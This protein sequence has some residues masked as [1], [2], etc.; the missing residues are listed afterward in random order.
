LIDFH[1]QTGSHA[2][3]G[4]RQAETYMKLAATTND[5][6]IRSR[7]QSTTLSKATGDLRE[8][9]QRSWHEPV[10][11]LHPDKGG[12]RE[13]MVRLN[14]RGRHALPRGGGAWSPMTVMRAMKRLGISGE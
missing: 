6:E 11:E 1:R 10:K 8:H 2:Y 4:E 12:S 13:A 3:R 9:H 14:S 5:I 7:P